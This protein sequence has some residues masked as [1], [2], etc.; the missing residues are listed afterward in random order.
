VFEEAKAVFLCSI[1][2]NRCQKGVVAKEVVEQK[3][4]MPLLAL[5]LVL[6]PSGTAGIQVRLVGG[7]TALACM[8]CRFV[9]GLQI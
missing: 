3:R 6:S 2:S 1:R 4:F 9:I 5:T 8:M 7:W